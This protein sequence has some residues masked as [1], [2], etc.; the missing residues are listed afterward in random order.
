MVAL[1]DSAPVTEAKSKAAS[2]RDGADVPGPTSMSLETIVPDPKLV[3][4]HDFVSQAEVQHLLDLAEGRWERSKTTR[5]AASDLHSNK[6]VVKT[7]E[8]AGCGC[9]EAAAEEAKKPSDGAK[10]EDEEPLE[11]RHL[12]SQTRTSWEYRLGY[13][14]SPV[15]ERILARVATL[16]GLPYDTVERPVLLRYHGGEYFKVTSAV[17]WEERDV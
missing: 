13:S 10:D 4:V 7:E 16:T 15:V 17:R 12:E 6:L 2:M 1:V 14:E 3:L 11:R 9:E 5:G 8:Q